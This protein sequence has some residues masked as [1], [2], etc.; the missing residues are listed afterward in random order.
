MPGL[1]PGILRFNGIAAKKAWMAELS[2][3]MMKPKLV[4]AREQE[5]HDRNRQ[6]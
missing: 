6:R 4:C 5:Q 1:V 2:P 3:A